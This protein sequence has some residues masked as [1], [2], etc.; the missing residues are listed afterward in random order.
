[1][2]QRKEISSKCCLD[3]T[4]PCLP[5]TLNQ[6]RIYDCSKRFRIQAS[7][8]AISE[9]SA[10]S[11]RQVRTCSVLA[12]EK[13]REPLTY[14]VVLDTPPNKYAGGHSDQTG[15]GDIAMTQTVTTRNVTLS[16]HSKRV[17]NSV[18]EHLETFFRSVLRVEWALDTSGHS[19]EVHLHVHARSG[20]YRCELPSR[21]GDRSNSPG[22]G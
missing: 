9:E 2:M 19:V 5:I 3:Q 20:H 6:S 13:I 8:Q 16:A 21:P 12:K 22:C 4:R 15:K 10:I 17:L 1:M 7:T 18:T 14:S 11:R